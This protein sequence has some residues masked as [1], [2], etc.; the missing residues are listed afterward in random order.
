MYSLPV[1]AAPAVDAEVTQTL[2]GANPNPSRTRPEP[3]PDPGEPEPNSDQE[4]LAAGEEFGGG[5]RP[6]LKPTSG[7]GRARPLHHLRALAGRG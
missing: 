7:R 1:D 3:E 6:V 5:A 2:S 4:R